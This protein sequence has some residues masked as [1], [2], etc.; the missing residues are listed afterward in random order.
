MKLR[1]PG[2]AYKRFLY[3]SPRRTC[4][5]QKSRTTLKAMVAASTLNLRNVTKSFFL[6]T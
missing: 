3:Q 1:D 6:G 5:A 4:T 2:P